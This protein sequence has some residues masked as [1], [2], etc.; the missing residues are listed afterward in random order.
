[1]LLDLSSEV[2]ADDLRERFVHREGEPPVVV[3]LFVGATEVNLFGI[4]A[5]H[6]ALTLFRIKVCKNVGGDLDRGHFAEVEIGNRPDEP[7]PSRCDNINQITIGPAPH[8]LLNPLAQVE[9][10]EPTDR[11]GVEMLDEVEGCVAEIRCLRAWS[12]L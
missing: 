4:A 1:M 3:P 9:R 12:I 6:L 11:L 7:V 8:Q 2:L 5:C 10:L